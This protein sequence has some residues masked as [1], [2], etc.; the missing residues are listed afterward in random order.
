MIDFAHTTPVPQPLSHRIPW[1]EANHEEGYLL[2]LD[3]LVAFFEQL[4]A[5]APPP[6]PP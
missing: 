6:P 5:A 4:G 3:S 1:V 2:G